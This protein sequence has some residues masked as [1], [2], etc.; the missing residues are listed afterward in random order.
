[1]PLLFRERQNSFGSERLFS[2]TARQHE[3]SVPLPPLRSGQTA[4]MA[5]VAATGMVNALSRKCCDA[6]FLA[7][8][9]SSRCMKSSAMRPMTAIGGRISLR[10]YPYHSASPWRQQTRRW[11]YH[12]AG[13]KRVS[14]FH[15]QRKQ[16]DIT[17]VLYLT[18]IS[19]RRWLC[20]L[21]GGELS[22]RQVKLLSAPGRWR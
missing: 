7:L 22:R 15:K 10:P 18:R 14:P 2:R 20:S 8:M 13:D 5:A 3:K 11:R 17:T 4:K 12:R 1:M 21:T 6:G 9:T 19:D 16:H